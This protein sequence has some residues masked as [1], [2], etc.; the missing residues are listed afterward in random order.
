LLSDALHFA[1]SINLKLREKPKNAP[2]FQI[3]MEKDPDVA[4]GLICLAS[5]IKKK[6]CEV[7]DS[8]FPFLKKFDEN[9]THNMLALMLNPRFKSFHLMFFFIVHDQG[10]AI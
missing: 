4:L 2:S 3:L 6:V 8:F 1:I 9:K 7:L 10:V 5:N